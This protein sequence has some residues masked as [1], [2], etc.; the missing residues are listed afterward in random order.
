M[1]IKIILLVIFISIA[2]SV[3]GQSV[4]D[5]EYKVTNDGVVITGYNGTAK[6]IVIP[7]E[8]NEILVVEIGR[9]AFMK[10]GLV[11]VII[12]NSVKKIG[13]SAFYGN[14]LT[15]ITIPKSVQKIGCSSFRGN[16]LT[17]VVIPKSTMIVEISYEVGCNDDGED[18]EVYTGIFTFD[19]NVKVRRKR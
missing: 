10:K 15:K 2:F 19:D 18:C 12:P 7:S 5:F 9:E 14:E 13:E 11:S 6:D 17:K 1:K 8:I 4:S 16:K 3:F